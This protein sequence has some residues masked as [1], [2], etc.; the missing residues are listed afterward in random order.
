MNRKYLLGILIAVSFATQAT[1]QNKKADSLKVVT[2]FKELLFICKNVYFAD[3]KVQD[4]GTFYKA[5]SYIIYRGDDKQRNWKDFANYKVYEEKLRVNDVCIKINETINRDSSYTIDKYFTE[6]E[7]EGTWHVLLVTYMKKDAA[8]KTAF[9]FL[10]VKG[11][12]G[13][14]DID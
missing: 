4:S 8:K 11:R 9:A 6:T 5:A 12:F 3:S 14:G 1:A 10:K 2:T 13:L 7:S